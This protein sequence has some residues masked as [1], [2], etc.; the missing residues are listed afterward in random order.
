MSVAVNTIAESFVQ[1]TIIL[2]ALSFQNHLMSVTSVYAGENAK[3]TELT[4]LLSKQMQWLSED[5]LIPE[6]ISKPAIPKPAVPK[7]AIS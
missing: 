4:T 1:D 5:I 3:Q 6:A 7:P 2:L